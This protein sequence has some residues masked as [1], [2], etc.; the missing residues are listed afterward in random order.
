MPNDKGVKKPRHSTALPA[1][2]AVRH[3]VPPG[4]QVSLHGLGKLAVR[5]FG[6][7]LR[8]RGDLGRGLDE[9][10][11]YGPRRKGSRPAGDGA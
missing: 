6:N 5:L 8:E 7:E 11:I 3:N 1:D 9:A 10:A 2:F 4:M